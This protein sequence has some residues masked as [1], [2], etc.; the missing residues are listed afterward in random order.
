[1]GVLPNTRVVHAGL[2]KRQHSP[3]LHVPR[4]PQQRFNT[5]AEIDIVTWINGRW[6]CASGA[7]RHD[8]GPC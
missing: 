7:A 4:A 5:G 3:E 8:A 1:M 6:A 2:I